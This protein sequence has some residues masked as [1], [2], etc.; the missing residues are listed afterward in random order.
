[1]KY[2]KEVKTGIITIVA[3]L[4]LV[5][6]VN[7][8]KG[9]SFFGGDKEYQAFFSNSS[10]LSASS[11]VYL[12]GVNIGKV[13]TVENLLNN[14]KD[15]MVK[16]VFN[17]QDKNIR[18]PKGSIVEIGSADLFSKGIILHLNED[19]SKG[20]YSS[21]DE[22]LGTVTE[23]ILAQVKSYV[24]PIGQK[25]TAIMSNV[26][27][28][29]STAAGLWDT[30]ATSEIEGSI[31][32]IKDAITRFSNMSKS[33]ESMVSTEK[34]QIHKILSNVESITKNLELTNGRVQKII[35]NA[36][37]ITDDILTGD[38]KNVILNAQ[39][40]IHKLN[41]ILEDVEKGN[42][43]IGKLLKDEKLYSELIQSNKAL[44]DLVDDL[45]LHPER[46]IHF[47]VFGSKIK[48]V[49]LSPGEEK[50]LRKL[51]DSVPY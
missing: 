43:T 17:I 13:L 45:K 14:P 26:D 51:M 15:K 19:V 1:M 32:E 10:G 3:I 40:S 18:I 7:F 34:I 33:L 30:S 35:G 44:Q 42:G 28:I 36:E 16:V 41:L 49:P 4:L 20:Y 37:K 9:S 46:Y 25:L 27:K 31:H 48:G 11:A 6:G 47:S 29:V 39:N 23:D 21:E 12:N 24:D 2:T 50:K 22:I 5:A 38:F 8:L